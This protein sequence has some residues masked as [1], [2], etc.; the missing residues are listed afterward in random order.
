MTQSRDDELPMGIGR[1]RSANKTCSAIFFAAR[2]SVVYLASAS[3]ANT[4][5]TGK[6]ATQYIRIPLV[7]GRTNMIELRDKRVFEPVDQHLGYHN[8]KN[9][10]EMIDELYARVGN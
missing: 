6:V 4:T 10:L 9:R 2:S 1:H 8:A 3:S 7:Y 5:P